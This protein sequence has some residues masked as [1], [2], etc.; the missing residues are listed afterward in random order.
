MPKMIQ[1][2]NVPDK[3]HRELKKRAS[4]RGETLT[5]YIQRLL[6]RELARPLASEVFERIEQ[7]EPVRL[8]RRAADL[9]SEERGQRQAS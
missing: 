6:E 9:I 3:M 1:V 8:G 7:R 5:D 2:R 4:A